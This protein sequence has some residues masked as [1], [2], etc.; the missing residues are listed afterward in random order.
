MSFSAGGY[1]RCSGCMTHDMCEQQRDVAALLHRAVQVIAR[2]APFGIE[3]VVDVL[4]EYEER[5]A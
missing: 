2:Y 4:A 1:P 3:E 5:F